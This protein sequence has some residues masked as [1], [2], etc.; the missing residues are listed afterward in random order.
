VR[1]KLPLRPWRLAH[2]WEWYCEL[3][4]ARVEGEPI[5]WA[6]IEAYSRLMGVGITS[7]EASL[8]RQIDDEYFAGL[9]KRREIEEAESK[10]R[11]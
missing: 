4:S 5:R 3:G 1:D 8:L 11:K 6:E 7:F 9:K 10:R 2:V